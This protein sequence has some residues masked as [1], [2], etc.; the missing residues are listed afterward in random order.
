MCGIFGFNWKNEQNASEISNLLKHRGPDGE[1]FLFE[2]NLTLGHRRLSIIDL[3]ELGKQ[4]MCNEDETIW[5][6]F[7]G[8]IFNFQEIKK[9]LIEKGHVFRSKTDTEVIIHGYEE[10]GTDILKK[11]NGQFAFCI[12]DKKKEELFLARDRIGI[13]PLYYYVKDGKFIFGS[14]LKA[15]MKMGIEKKI[16]KFALNYYLI[17]GYTP[18]KQSILENCFKLEAGHFLIFNLKSSK[19]DKY[20]RY[21]DVKFTNEIKDEETAKKLILKQLERSVK[22]RMVADVPVGAFLSGG[23]DSSA[24]VAIMS[25]YTNNLN[26]FSVKFDHDDFD[27]SEFA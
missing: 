20:K 10:Y 9:D 3:S 2:D 8:E 7:N 12:Y 6:T 18:K 21:W 1:G 25:K 23:V 13:N 11:L 5:I 15:I 4:P 14:E 19:I 17:Y 22:A 27:E 24:V 26:T 16:N